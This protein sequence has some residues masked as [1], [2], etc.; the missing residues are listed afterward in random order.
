LSDFTLSELEY[1]L[2]QTYLKF[3]KTEFRKPNLSTIILLSF[4]NTVRKTRLCNYWMQNVTKSRCFQCHRFTRQWGNS[5]L[6][7]QV[8]VQSRLYLKC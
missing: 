8:M 7:S 3:P 2:Y 4:K 6:L 5:E 1:Q